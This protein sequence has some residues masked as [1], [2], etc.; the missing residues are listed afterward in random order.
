MSSAGHSVVVIRLALAIAFALGLSGLARASTVETPAPGHVTFDTSFLGQEGSVPDISRFEESATLLPGRYEL[1]VTVNAT[2]HGDMLLRMIDRADGRGTEPCLTSV[3]LT[4]WGVKL[5]PDLIEG[6]DDLRCV[7]L[8]TLV[9]GASVTVKPSRLSIR[10][11]VPQ[12]FMSRQVRGYVDPSRWSEGI[13]AATL[14]YGL[15]AYRS[16]PAHGIAVSSIFVRTD[17]GLNMDGWR[18]RHQGALSWETGAALQTRSFASYATHDIT[19][20]K[21]EMLVGDTATTGELFDAVPFTGVQVRTDDR[22]FPDALAGYAPVIRGVARTHANVLIRQNG[23][24]VYQLAVTPGPFEIDDMHPSGFGGDLEVIVRESDGTEERFMVPFATLPRLLRPGMHRY[25]GTLGQLRSP[26]G[27]VPLPFVEMTY[28]RGVN[29]VATLYGGS[30]ASAGSRYAA[31]TVG[32]ALN[33]AMGALSADV[34]LSRARLAQGEARATGHSLRTTYSKHLATSATHV[35]FVAL[36]HSSAGYLSLSDASTWQ[37]QARYPGAYGGVR[38]PTRNTLQLNVTQQLASGRGTVFAAGASSDYWEEQGRDTSYQLGYSR[39]WR[40]MMFSL[41]ASRTHASTGQANQQVNLS[42][43]MPLGR[44]EE[45][46]RRLG[47][48][49]LALGDHH[50][51]RVDLSG[52]SGSRRQLDYQVSASNDHGGERTWSAGGGY[53]FPYAGMNV[54]ASHA[55]GASQQSVFVTGGMV[56]HAGGV[57]LA[58]SLPDTVALVHAEGATGARIAGH[59][60]SRIDNHGYAVATNLRA[61][62]ENT[63]TIDPVDAGQLVHFASS[64]QRAAPRAGAV[65]RLDFTASSSRAYIV[66]MIDGEGRPL[67]FGADVHDSDGRVVGT[68]A[69]GGYAWLYQGTPGK[70]MHVRWMAGGEGGACQFRLPA[71]HAGSLAVI[72]CRSF[73]GTDRVD[74][75]PA[76][77]D[78]KVAHVSVTGLHEE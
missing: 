59:G 27:G 24:E 49:Y 66:R 8:A 43:S 18:L 35:S 5:A 4:A 25:A 77:H 30:Q 12:A 2:D 75:P 74:H 61:Y 58:P 40:T 50:A 31:G 39:A 29:N 13:T 21:A 62:R 56:A 44:Q 42:M 60:H 71:D 57:T 51:Q 45:T 55:G 19:P 69:Q 63:V 67:P 28:Q 11:Q 46:S 41:V 9:P 78:E 36:R 33:T 3:A 48:N 17:I 15:N 6:M 37:Y 10:L 73:D 23:Y 38:Q 14:N 52:A 72:A 76:S 70:A 34:T 68:V 53:Q 22:M 32:A 20:W 65:V 7:D 47:I 26:A 1:A 16:T 54:S 64:S